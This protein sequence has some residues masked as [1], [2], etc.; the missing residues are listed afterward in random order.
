MQ[1]VAVGAPKGT[2]Q[3]TFI[4]VHVRQSNRIS[5]VWPQAWSIKNKEAILY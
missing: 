3:L 2:E 1:S 4:I 5:Y